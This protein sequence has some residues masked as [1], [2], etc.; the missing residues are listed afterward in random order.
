MLNAESA[1][2]FSRV[3]FFQKN[4]IVY[5]TFRVEF[6]FKD[7]FLNCKPGIVYPPPPTRKRPSTAMIP[8]A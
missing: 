1:A 5:A 2:L 7:L 3:R 8:A 6:K 4:V